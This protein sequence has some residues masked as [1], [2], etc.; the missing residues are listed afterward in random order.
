MVSIINLYPTLQLMEMVN[1][2]LKKLGSG[3]SSSVFLTSDFVFIIVG[4]CLLKAYLNGTIGLAKLK[5]NENV[6]TQYD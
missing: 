1:H 5:E 2:M 4:Q 3:G 6:V